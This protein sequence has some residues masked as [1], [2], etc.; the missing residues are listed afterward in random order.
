MNVLFVTPYVPSVI[1]A[2]SFNFIKG[3]VAKGH[4]VSLISLCSGN[5]EVTPELA[6]T[7]TRVITVK[8]GKW[9]Q[10]TNCVRALLAGESLWVGS[11]WSR[12][13]NEAVA[14][15]CSSTEYDVLHVEHIRASSYAR[16]ARARATVLDAVDCM[17]PLVRKIALGK[18]NPLARAI[19][20]M[21]S[22]R[23]DRREAEI[24][25]GF[26]R[27]VITSDIEK[28]LLAS[29]LPSAVIDV[30][31][32]GVD[33]S[34]F[35]VGAL[36]TSEAKLVFTGKMSY[37]PN[38]DGAS[39]FAKEVF[40][41]L[42]SRHSQ[43]TLTIAGAEPPAEIQKLSRDSRIVV[44]GRV[45]K[46]SDV[47]HKSSIA[48]CPLRIAAGAQFKVIEAMACGLPVV[49]SPL[50]ARTITNCESLLVADT[51]DEWVGHLC[52][53]IESPDEAREL[54]M[55][56]RAYVEQ[57]C[58]WASSV[59]RLERVYQDAISDRLARCGGQLEHNS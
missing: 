17:G 15:E 5:E 43:A 37:F 59:D 12:Q 7:C 18:R 56:N 26:D 35:E 38:S 36:P 28:Q 47:L 31:P 32:I 52:R 8:M 41:E 11:C 50:A 10:M 2:R 1:R 51:V 25:Q 40:P 34:E 22:R 54:G 57:N 42:V 53:L 24:A 46:L 44:T 20:K 30:V 33:L 21:E 49:A 58:S 6:D 13:V 14:A 9:T 29:K 3:L 55:R 19:L 48:V 16:S 4:S 39:W 45:A 27:V 23:L